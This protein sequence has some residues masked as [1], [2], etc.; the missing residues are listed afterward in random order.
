[1][2]AILFTLSSSL[3]GSGERLEEGIEDVAECFTSCYH[4]SHFVY[5]VLFLGSGER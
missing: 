1:M 3:G 2:A 5:F 4:G